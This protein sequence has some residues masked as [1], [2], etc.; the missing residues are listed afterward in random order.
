MT[1]QIAIIWRID[2][3]L[4]LRPDLTRD[5]ARQVLAEVEAE[6]YARCCIGWDTLECAADTLFERHEC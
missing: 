5:Q 1:D 3:V 4:E 2:D 6:Y